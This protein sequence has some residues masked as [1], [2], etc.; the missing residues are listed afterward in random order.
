MEIAHKLQRDQFNYVIT[1]NKSDEELANACARWGTIFNTAGFR[2]LVEKSIG[3]RRLPKIL[4]T[5]KDGGKTVYCDP[6]REDILFDSVEEYERDYEGHLEKTREALLKAKVFVLTLGL[7]EV[8][9]L[10]SDG[11]IFSHAPWRVASGLIGRKIMTV[12][13]NLQ[14]LQRMLEIWRGANPELK[15]IVSVSPV[16]LHATFRGQD[17]HVIAA[18]CHSKA[19]LRV[20][21]EEFAR[22]N[23]D[24]YYFPSYESVMY[25]T[26][27]A[28][29]ADL[30]HVSR[31]AVEKVMSLFNAMFVLK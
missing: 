24:V 25:C 9:F 4:W 11:S 22:R 5:K 3:D 17:T 29:E 26:P 18:T 23:K 31:P 21:A 19:V 20:A 1:E 28:W 8:W 12:E 14:D 13:E 10:K 30:R 7:N 15:I 16:P 2:Q 6:F 27:N